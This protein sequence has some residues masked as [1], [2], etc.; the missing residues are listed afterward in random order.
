[1]HVDPSLKVKA[2]AWL[3][4]SFSGRLLAEFVVSLLL[5]A[6]DLGMREGVSVIDTDVILLV[7]SIGSSI[8][9][10]WRVETLYQNA[11]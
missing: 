5:M 8:R 4:S 6:G 9:L 1:M 3:Q 11:T 10:V 7:K 2:I